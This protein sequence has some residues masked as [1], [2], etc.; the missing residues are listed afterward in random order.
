[1]GRA[2][3]GGE[4][5]VVMKGREEGCDGLWADDRRVAAA[6]CSRTVV[7]GGAVAVA[8]REVTRMEANK[9]GVLARKGA[10]LTEAGSR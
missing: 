4:E 2:G 8:G 9:E 1:M 10:R 3:S 5:G 6:C 7:E